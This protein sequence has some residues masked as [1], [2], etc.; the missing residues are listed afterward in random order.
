MYRHFIH[1][2]FY[3]QNLAIFSLLKIMLQ[4]YMLRKMNKGF[5]SGDAFVIFFYRLR[6]IKSYLFYDLRFLY[7]N[8]FTYFIA[9]MLL[10]F[11]GQR[12][13]QYGKVPK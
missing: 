8:I 5:L 9:K 2:I 11:Q 10:S 7:P 4:S 3:H 1:Y 13:I 12:Q 6:D